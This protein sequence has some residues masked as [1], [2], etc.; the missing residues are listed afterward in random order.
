MIIKWHRTGSIGAYLYTDEDERRGIVYRKSSGHIGVFLPEV[1]IFVQLV[2]DEGSWKLQRSDS[3]I[4]FDCATD[5]LDAAVAKINLLFH[6][7]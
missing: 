5:D 4:Y 7:E 6:T 1:D 3:S 2:L